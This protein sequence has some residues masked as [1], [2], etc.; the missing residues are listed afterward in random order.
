EGVSRKA[1]ASRLDIDPEAVR[2]RLKRP[3]SLG[4]IIN[5]SAGEKGKA[6]LYRPAGSGDDDS[7]SSRPTPK[8]IIPTPDDLFSEP[9]TGPP[10][11]GGED[12][13]PFDYA[14]A[15]LA[16]IHVGLEFPLRKT[17]HTQLS[18][19]AGPAETRTENIA[20]AEPRQPAVAKTCESERLR[21]ETLILTRVG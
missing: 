8:P 3:L 16:E 9:A 20:P 5:L 7:P 15:G 19:A 1:I 2:H 10:E 17:L 11:G 6:G 12:T 13:R 4:Y 14:G 18:A 21:R